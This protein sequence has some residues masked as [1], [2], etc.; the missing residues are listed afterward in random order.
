LKRVLVTGSS[1][2]I[3]SSFIEEKETAYLFKT[4][5]FQRE[6]F[7]ALLLDNFD[8]VVHLAALVH[9]PQIKDDAKYIEA[10][11]DK[12]I[13]LA[14]RAKEKG[15]KHFVFMSTIKVYGEASKEVCFHEK[16]ECKPVDGYG[17][18]KLEAERALSLLEDDKFVVSIIRTPV[19]Y[20]PKVKANIFSIVK[21][22]N[23]FPYL[24]FANIFNKRSM[25]Y[26]GNLI[27]LLDIVIEKRTSGVFLASDPEVF[28]TSEFFS[29]ISLS[30][31]HK[32]RLFYLPG[33]AFLLER[34]KPGVFQRLY[35]DLCLDASQ[36]Q[37]LLGFT[38][39]YTTKQGIEK[40]V[41]WYRH[42]T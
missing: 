11:C 6:S 33:F 16:S 4:F 41:A 29:W 38:P 26:I 39:K 31:H 40:M 20:G 14:K 34:I 36:T 10:N 12:T 7:D 5:S 2:F 21:L 22:L 17:K 32:T 19:V 24:P 25:V 28:S 27:Q 3:G 9:Q 23:W 13:A 8:T 42:D 30:L 18:S 35:T 15:V 1:G 37:K